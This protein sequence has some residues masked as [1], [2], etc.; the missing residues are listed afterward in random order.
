M[1][2]RKR[3][4]NQGVIDAP[5][6]GSAIAKAAPVAM[7]LKGPSAPAPKGITKDDR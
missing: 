7:T 5:D 3:G 1:L 2:I 4:E 6:E